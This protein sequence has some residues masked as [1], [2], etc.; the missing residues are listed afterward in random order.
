MR[1]TIAALAAGGLLAVAAAPALGASDVLI[2]EGRCDFEVNTG[3]VA[4][5]DHCNRMT[6][7]QDA[8]S[9]EVILTFDFASGMVVELEGPGIRVAEWMMMS[10]GRMRWTN[11]G[12]K[13]QELSN[14]AGE[15]NPQIT[16]RCSVALQ[17]AASY[18]TYC[19]LRTPLGDVNIG[20]RT[21]R[22]DKPKN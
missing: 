11:V 21:P 4:V 16:G 12:G 15:P 7:K 14:P 22:P 19:R 13:P 3:S 10:P 5:S 20:F 2:A 1:S 17:S 6:L 9:G 18:E 8:A